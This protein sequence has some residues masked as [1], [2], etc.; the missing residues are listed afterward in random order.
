MRSAALGRKL[1]TTGVQSF[2]ESFASAARRCCATMTRN[3]RVGWLFRFGRR[4]TLDRTL[5]LAAARDWLVAGANTPPAGVRPVARS[6]D[7][8]IEP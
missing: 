4:K 1:G 3:V 8:V 7:V 6:T 5:V 2:G